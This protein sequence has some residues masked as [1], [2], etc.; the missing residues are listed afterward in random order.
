M[1]QPRGM[2]LSLK[3]GLT[4]QVLQS[5][6]LKV[7]HPN[8]S[9]T[10]LMKPHPLSLI[11]SLLIVPQSGPHFFHSLPKLDLHQCCSV[12]SGWSWESFVPN[13]IWKTAKALCT[14]PKILFFSPVF[15]TTTM[16]ERA[17]FKLKC[18]WNLKEHLS[19]LGRQIA[20]ASECEMWSPQCYLALTC[21]VCY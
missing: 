11:P 15:C 20:Y 14:W 21:C 16:Q 19:G 13:V 8:T 9:G 6:T 3:C 4:M 10:Q 17:K 5:K 2:S 12:S 18:L 1:V 7:I